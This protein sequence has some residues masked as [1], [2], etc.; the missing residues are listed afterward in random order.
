MLRIALL[1]LLVATTGVLLAPAASAN[2]LVNEFCEDDLAYQFLFECS[3]WR[4]VEC[5]ERAVGS[6]LRYC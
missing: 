2:N 3:A 4:V 6:F 1:A 5:V